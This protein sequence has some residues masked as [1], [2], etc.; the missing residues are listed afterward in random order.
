MGRYRGRQ[1]AS[2]QNAMKL[3]FRLREDQIMFETE[4]VSRETFTYPDKT[5]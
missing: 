2:W 4:N 3:M 5:G 1:A